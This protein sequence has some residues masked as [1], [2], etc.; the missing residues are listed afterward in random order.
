MAASFVQN[1]A[2]G[3]TATSS[4]IKQFKRLVNCLNFR[5]NINKVLPA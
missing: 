3:M 2:T 1:D 4:F 5:Q